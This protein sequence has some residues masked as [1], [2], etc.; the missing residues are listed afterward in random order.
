MNFRSVYIQRNCII[1]CVLFI[2]L[3][4]QL[5][6]DCSDIKGVAN[7]Q[8]GLCMYLFVISGSGVLL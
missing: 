3:N 5:Y 2:V 1:L 8:V 6:M 4:C 7:F